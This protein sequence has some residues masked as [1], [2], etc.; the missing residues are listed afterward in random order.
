MFY[1][2]ADCLGGN[3]SI[4]ELTGSKVSGV[5]GW[6]HKPGDDTSEPGSTLGK[7]LWKIPWTFRLT[8][9]PKA[10]S[11]KPL[12]PKKPQ[13]QSL[14]KLKPESLIEAPKPKP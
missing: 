9:K 6:L 3:S 4:W 10:L 14:I 1:F 7:Q 8:P 12:E 11:P 2:C 5:R 13:T